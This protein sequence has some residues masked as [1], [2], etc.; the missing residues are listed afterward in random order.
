VD[1]WSKPKRAVRGQ[2]CR[3][4][5]I[6][7]YSWQRLFILGDDKKNFP[8]LAPW[9]C[10]AK[11]TATEVINKEATNSVFTLFCIKKLIPLSHYKCEEHADDDETA[12]EAAASIWSG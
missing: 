7:E 6:Q 5:G 12:D 9:T 10:Y 11:S 3:T 2:V 8:K 4:R 1:S